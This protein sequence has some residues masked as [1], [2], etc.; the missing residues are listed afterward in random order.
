MTFA[1]PVG[2]ITTTVEEITLE[3]EGQGPRPGP[4]GDGEV[5]EL[6]IRVR[7]AETDQMGVVHHSK[8]F[9]YF[10]MGRTEFLRQSGMTYRDLEEQ[11]VFLVIVKLVCNFKA[12]ARYDDLLCLE[13]WVERFTRMRI[14]HGYRL[15]RDEKRQLVAEATSTLGCVDREGRLQELPP[16]LAALLEKVVKSKT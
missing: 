15:W 5:H 3:K 13:T 10:E 7:Y 9:V 6:P 11:G 2:N 16:A 4:T 1:R 14:D 12:P 8:Y